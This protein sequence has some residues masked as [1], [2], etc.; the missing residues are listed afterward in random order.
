MMYHQYHIIHTLFFFPR[1]QEATSLG[2]GAQFPTFTLP[3][4]LIALTNSDRF[5]GDIEEVKSR[6]MDILNKRGFDNVFIT[7]YVVDNSS[8]GSSEDEIA[9]LRCKLYELCSEILGKQRPVP[10]RWLKVL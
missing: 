9:R 10:I 2:S 5:E 3:P 7:P 6:I 8:S 4:V 1:L